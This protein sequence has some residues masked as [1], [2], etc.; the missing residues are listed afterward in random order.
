[1]STT[2][3]KY[4]ATP[5]AAPAHPRIKYWTAKKLSAA[6]VDVEVFQTRDG[7]VR[8]A[9]RLFVNFYNKEDLVEVQDEVPWEIELDEWLVEQGF[10]AADRDK[11]KLRFSF[12][13]AHAFRPIIN[14]Y[15]SDYFGSVLIELI[16]AGP[17]AD[18]PDIQPLL[19]HI[20]RGNPSKEFR[21]ECEERIEEQLYKLAGKIKRICSEQAE[22]TA[23]ILGGALAH[24]LDERY[25]VSD[26]KMLGWA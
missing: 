24:Y 16:K 5:P 22:A 2:K 26:R 4:V 1:M 18:H 20:L 19:P 15:G 11:E 10:P 17:F 6:R 23:D 14:R 25:S 21:E 12:H 8:S 9:P 3:N 13:I 7:L